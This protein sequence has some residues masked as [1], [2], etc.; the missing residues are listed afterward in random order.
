MVD[1]SPTG[2]GC[3]VLYVLRMAAK[4]KDKSDEATIENRRARHDYEVIRTLEVGVALRGSEVKSI[5]AGRASI[6]EGFVRAELEPMCRLTLE[7][8]HVDEYGPAKGV[9]QHS[10]LR[11]R[12]LLAHR[13]EIRKLAAEAD[14]KG[15][16][17]VPLKMYFKDG[18]VKLLIGLARGKQAHDR[19][20][21]IRKR[22][23]ER[24][25]RRTLSKRV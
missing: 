25:I 10:P 21:D 9:N 3:G 1:A 22:D 17:I 18:R 19:R 24:D 6:S 12:S 7:G 23:V 14:A 16:T 20:E 8:M 4:G 15:M 11:T 2:A 5:R 13:K